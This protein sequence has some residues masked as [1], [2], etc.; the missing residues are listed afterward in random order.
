M[1]RRVTVLAAAALVAAGLFAGWG[2]WSWLT[3]ARDDTLAAAAARDEALR[4]GREHVAQVTTLDYRDVEAGIRRWL[5]V[6]TGPLRDE[7]AATDERTRTRLREGGT[8]ATGRVLE[9]ALSELDV[10]AGTA[11]MLVSVEITTARDGTEPAAT[12]NR[13]VAGL[14]RTDGGWKLS[15]LDAVPVG[16]GAS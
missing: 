15:A 3:A 11:K 5:A 14:R 7:Y 6:S 2:A 13:F 8:V 16:G 10:E 12:R 1:A 9:A 4:A